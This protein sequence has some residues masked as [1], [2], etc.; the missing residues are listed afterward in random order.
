MDG[1]RLRLGEH[2]VAQTLV[3]L[4]DAFPGV[5]GETFGALDL[6]ELEAILS[7]AK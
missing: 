5:T 1:D 7:L 2:H 4:L 3:F 6:V